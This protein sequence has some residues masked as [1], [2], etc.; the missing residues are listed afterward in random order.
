MSKEPE[1]VTCTVDEEISVYENPSRCP[2]LTAVG[3]GYEMLLVPGFR[4]ASHL[5]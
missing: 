3:Y 5:L 1:K 4:A 2:G